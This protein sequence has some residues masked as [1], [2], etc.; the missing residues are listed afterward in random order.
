MGYPIIEMQP[1]G[2][3]YVTKHKRTGGLV[4][5]K[6]VKEQ[7]VYEMG[8]P[9]QYISP[10]GVAFFDTIQVEETGKDRVQD[11]RRAG[12]AGAGDVQGLH[13]LRGR[14]EGR[15]RGAGLRAGHRGKGRR[16][17]GD[18]LGK[19]GPRL[20]A[21]LHRPGRA[22][23]PSGPTPLAGCEPNEIYLRFGVRDHDHRQDRWTSAR[24]CR[25]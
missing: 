7:L 3:F 19:G 2:E 4:S 5:E 25:P 22:R 15:G 21:D 6:S 18:L 20:R 9:A 1:T 17:G 13:G 14:L 23:P 24:P 8:D 12:R 10:D 11:L 16:R